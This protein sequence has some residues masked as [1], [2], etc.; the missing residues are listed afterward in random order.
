VLATDHV[1]GVDVRWPSLSIITCLFVV[2][3]ACELTRLPSSFSHHKS[4]LTKQANF[5][6]QITETQRVH[7]ASVFGSPTVAAYAS[8]GLHAQA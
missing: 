7:G 4:S 1:L 6:N 5:P 2:S 8:S 3:C